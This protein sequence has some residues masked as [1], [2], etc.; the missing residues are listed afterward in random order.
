MDVAAL[1]GRRPPRQL[2]GESHVL[3]TAECTVTNTG[4]VRGDEVVFLFSNSSAA[5]A[6]WEAR[7]GSDGPDPLAMKQVRVLIRA[8]LY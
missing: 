5:Q 3:T 7:P 2:R 6:G 8:N 4:A 1:A